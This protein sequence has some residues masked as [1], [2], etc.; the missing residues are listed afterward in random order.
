MAISAADLL[1]DSAGSLWVHCSC[2]GRTERRCAHVGRCV[3]CS[4]EWVWLEE[5]C[6]VL[7]IAPVVRPERPPDGDGVGGRLVVC[8]GCAGRGWK[9]LVRLRDWAGPEVV[10]RVVWGSCVDCGGAGFAWR[11]GGDV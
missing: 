6:V 8:S 5:A 10:S 3:G 11:G 7:G 4:P 9:R 1:A 2:S